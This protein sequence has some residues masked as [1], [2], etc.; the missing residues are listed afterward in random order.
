MNNKGAYKLSLIAEI[1]QEKQWENA[2]YMISQT[3]RLSC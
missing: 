1:I 3:W 2:I